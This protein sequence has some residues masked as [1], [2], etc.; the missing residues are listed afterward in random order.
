MTDSIVE[1]CREWCELAGVPLAEEHYLQA[2][3]PGM[4]I[5][6][7]DLLLQHVPDHILITLFVRFVVEPVMLGKGWKMYTTQI[8][9]NSSVTLLKSGDVTKI[10]YATDSNLDVATLKA[11]VGALKQ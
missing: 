3:T 7:V 8:S 5:W 9:G 6:Q 11:A 10:H 1:Q 2:V 4:E